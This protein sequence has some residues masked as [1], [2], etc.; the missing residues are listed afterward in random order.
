M[1]PSSSAGLPAA[2]PLMT[3]R[4]DG[5]GAPGLQ[6][7][8]GRHPALDGR[9]AGPAPDTAQS[10]REYRPQCQ[11]DPRIWRCA[12]QQQRRTSHS[13]A[14]WASSA[15][16]IAPILL[17]AGSAPLPTATMGDGRQSGGQQRDGRRRA[18]RR[19]PPAFHRRCVC[20]CQRCP[21]DGQPALRSLILRDARGGL[22]KDRRQLSCRW[23]HW[24]PPRLPHCRQ[25]RIVT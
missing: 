6:R 25:T 18:D 13:A 10:A 2:G 12:S 22:F 20:C 3:R 21:A 1:K 8:S 16:S 14:Q 4:P 11:Q 15:S 9:N 17:I 24:H 23:R 5:A 7:A 19:E